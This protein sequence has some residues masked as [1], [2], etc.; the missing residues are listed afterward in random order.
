[1]SSQKFSAIG[2]ILAL[3]EMVWLGERY[4]ILPTLGLV[5]VPYEALSKK[6]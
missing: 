5:G 2:P 4:I 3:K 1:M 6:A